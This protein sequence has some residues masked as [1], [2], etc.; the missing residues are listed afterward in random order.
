ME[1][2]LSFDR[3]IGYRRAKMDFVEPPKNTLRFAYEDGRHDKMSYE[4]QKEEDILKL[5]V[6][7]EINEDVRDMTKIIKMINTSDVIHVL[8]RHL[9]NPVNEIRL[10]ASQSMIEICH[11]FRGREEIIK[12]KYIKNLSKLSDDALPQIRWNIYK[13]LYNLSEH[14]DGNTACLANDILELC[15]DKLIEEKEENVLFLILQLLKRLLGGEG[16]VPRLLKT[17]GIVRLTGLLEKESEGVSI[18]ILE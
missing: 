6:L 18:R 9:E 14:V 7:N 1:E 15:V 4:L 17:Q 16:A 12:Y 3:Q 5:K 13:S 11:I 10:L 8:I 2:N